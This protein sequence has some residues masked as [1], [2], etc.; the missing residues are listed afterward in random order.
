MCYFRGEI[1]SQVNFKIPQVGG[2]KYF[3]YIF[4]QLF[5]LL[6]IKKDFYSETVKAL[7]FLTLS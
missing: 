1:T 6:F 3:K 5:S 7:N 4:K 2:L